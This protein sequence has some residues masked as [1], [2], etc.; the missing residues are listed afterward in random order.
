MNYKVASDNIKKRS[1]RIASPP[2]QLTADTVSNA[3]IIKNQESDG[4][5]VLSEQMPLT[6]NNGTSPP[7]INEEQ[8][9]K[10]KLST[11][12]EILNKYKFWIIAAIILALLLF[13]AIKLYVDTESSKGDLE[14]ISIGTPSDSFNN[15]DNPLIEIL[16]KSKSV[17]TTSPA[18][19]ESF[20]TEVPITG[21]VEGGTSLKNSLKIPL[22]E[23]P[24]DLPE[25][26]KLVL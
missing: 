17:P 8:Y 12:L 11:I 1:D 14:V 7:F 2:T 9:K 20:S 25:Q 15:E 3:S 23:V 22:I 13:M 24:L 19:I 6:P 21:I 5:H 4:I 10:T 18:P 16:G 26:P